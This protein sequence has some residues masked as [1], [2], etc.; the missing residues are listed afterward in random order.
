VTAL[1]VLA[2]TLAVAEITL[3]IMYTA[4]MQA[5]VYRSGWQPQPQRAPSVHKTTTVLTDPSDLQDIMSRRDRPLDVVWFVVAVPEVW[6]RERPSPSDASSTARYKRYALG[7]RPIIEMIL[8]AYG[9]KHDI[10][11]VYDL[12]NLGRN[13]RL[14]MLIPDLGRQVDSDMN[15]V[16]TSVM[17]AT[18]NLLWIPDKPDLTRK[19]YTVQSKDQVSRPAL[20]VTTNWMPS[21]DRVVYKPLLDS[22][23]TASEGRT[24]YL[25]SPPPQ[26]VSAS[27]VSSSRVSASRVSSSRVSSSRVSASRKRADGC[28]YRGIEPFD[29]KVVTE[30]D[31]LEGMLAHLSNNPSCSVDV[32]WFVPFSAP[33][34]TGGDLKTARMIRKVERL[35]TLYLNAQLVLVYDLRPLG[36]SVKKTALLPDVGRRVDAN[37]HVVGMPVA[38]ELVNLVVDAARPVLTRLEVP[39]DESVAI[40]VTTTDGSEGV[41]PPL[42]EDYMR[43][44]LCATGRTRQLFGT[45]WY[46]AV[47]SVLFLT[48][49]LLIPILR[50][51][52]PRTTFV[53]SAFHEAI[54]TQSRSSPPTRE[55]FATVARLIR[56]LANLIHVQGRRL[57]SADNAVFQGRRLTSITNDAVLFLSRRVKSMYFYSLPNPE[58][59]DEHKEAGHALQGLVISVFALFA[60]DPVAAWQRWTRAQTSVLFTETFVCDR[61]DAH[62]PIMRLVGFDTDAENARAVSDLPGWRLTAGIITFT[63]SN[64]AD[65]A[66]AGLMCGPNPYVYDSN[67]ELSWED[68]R[69][70]ARSMPVSVYTPDGPSA[71]RRVVFLPP[72]LTFNGGVSETRVRAR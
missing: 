21:F 4:Q 37:G 25:P 55:D 38:R 71:T 61:N 31:K 5:P 44:R 51:T 28:V 58:A 68:W 11:F 9:K 10:V 60:D 35:L 70:D 67:G 29:P 18:I 41:Y 26:R 7:L 22:L 42:L 30:R 2:E 63:R 59:G 23:S 24:S 20:V 17:R 13:V 69:T 34:V 64:G 6:A 33:M 72:G 39:V 43:L 32:V 54:P 16:G 62:R 14:T 15:V 36:P 47:L 8:N 3:D 40:V 65:H 48:P 57:T 66:V 56:M 49:S 12:R 53:E 45:C 27:R 19:V 1:E 50:D 52:P 46:S